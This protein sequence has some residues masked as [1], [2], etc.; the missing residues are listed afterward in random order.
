M[1]RC[2]CDPQSCAVVKDSELWQLWLCRSC[3]SHLL[4]GLQTS[5]CCGWGQK[6]KRERKKEINKLSDGTVSN[7][8]KMNKLN[9]KLMEGN[10]KD[11]SRDKQN[12]EQK[13]REKSIN[14]KVGSL[15]RSMKL[16][17]LQ[18]DRLREDSNYKD[19]KVEALLLILQK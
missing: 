6:K 19:E 13:N 8:K 1:L 2:G 12:K 4:P 9:P 11:Q 17:N 7:Q 18:L 3:S 14:T 5:I 15:K 10:N 16:I